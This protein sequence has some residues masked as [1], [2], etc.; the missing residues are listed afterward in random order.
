[1]NGLRIP[2]L[3]TTSS[4]LVEVTVISTVKVVQPIFGIL[5]C[6]RMNDIE[7]DDKAHPVSG[8]NQRLEVVRGS[9]KLKPSTF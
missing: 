9:C 5:G 6:V 4:S 3:M 2:K 7:K 8:I 1:M